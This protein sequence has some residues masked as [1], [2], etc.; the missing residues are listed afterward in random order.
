GTT[1][2]S[3]EGGTPG[4]LNSVARSGTES[5]MRVSVDPDP[6][7]PDGDGREDALA[8]RYRIDATSVFLHVRVF[9]AAGRE[10]R[11]LASDVLAPG[12]GEVWW[13][14]KADGGRTVPIGAYIILLQATDARTGS[15]YAAKLVAV[16][17]R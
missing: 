15:S 4:R 16:V 11:S 8:I 6:F 12:T 14:G 9:D 2:T 5:G 17:A 1:C 10:L 3:I 13:D 7:S